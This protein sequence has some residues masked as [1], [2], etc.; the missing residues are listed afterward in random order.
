MLFF[1]QFYI[2][3]SFSLSLFI[4]SSYEYILCTYAYGLCCRRGPRRTFPETYVNETASCVY[5][6]TSPWWIVN[7]GHD[8]DNNNN[9]LICACVL[10]NARTG[11]LVYICTVGTLRY[12]PGQVVYGW[13][14]CALDIV[15]RV[16]YDRRTFQPGQTIF[17][18]HRF[19]L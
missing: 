7:H 17:R 11:L 8:D 13:C 2:S 9:I 16:F 18:R 4:L 19:C 12:A 5:S 3:V 15:T 1:L 14:V 10:Y 6:G